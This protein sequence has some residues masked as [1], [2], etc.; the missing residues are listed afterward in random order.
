MTATTGSDCENPGSLGMSA[1]KSS[2]PACAQICWVVFVIAL[3]LMP[4]PVM[5]G[6]QLQ[7]SIRTS[8]YKCP[9][10]TINGAYLSQFNY[11]QSNRTLLYNLALNITFTNPKKKLFHTLID[12]KLSAYYQDKRI[13]QVTLMD[14]W[15]STHKNTAVFQNVAVQEHDILLQEYATPAADL[16][17][18]NVVI[19]FQD[20]N[21]QRGEVIYNLRLPLSFNGTSWDADK[22]ANCPIHT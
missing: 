8:E 16:Y 9:D 22:T 20:E 12:V 18:I 1:T 2:Q 3:F 15:T 17:S 21:N 7:S 11:T 6:L 13:G 4:L 19:A 5:I 14:L 10:F